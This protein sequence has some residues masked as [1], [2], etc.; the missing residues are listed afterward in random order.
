MSEVI[1][2]WR[3]PANTIDLRW[4]RYRTRLALG[5]SL[6]FVGGFLVQFTSAYSLVA[7]PVGLAIHVLGWCI[8]PGIGWR[9]VLGSAVSALAMIAL[10]N[11]AGA[12]WFLAFPLAA[13]LLLR[14]RPPI[15]YVTLVLPVIAMFLLAEL[16]PEY[17]YSIIV[18]A[19]ATAVLVG[20]AWLARGLAVI[21]RARS[22]I[23]G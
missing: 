4:G 1:S 8:L 20:A 15:S 19:I 9:R 18:L 11:G 12:T 3:E 7:L 6:A 2:T 13:W 14:Q 22:A 17:G 16:F 21:V 10:L 23:S 5:V